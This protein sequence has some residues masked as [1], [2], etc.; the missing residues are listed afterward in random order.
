MELC[1]QGLN[2][3]C[4]SPA[5]PC[6]APLL[7]RWLRDVPAALR[8]SAHEESVMEWLS[9]TPGSIPHHTTTT[10]L[11]L[12]LQAECPNQGSA[13]CASSFANLPMGGSTDGGIHSVGQHTGWPMGSPGVHLPCLA[14]DSSDIPL[15]EA[16]SGPQ[17]MTGGRLA[18][19]IQLRDNM[20]K[21]FLFPHACF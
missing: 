12:Q 9:E 21:C 3:S 4:K 7:P 20:P 10:L 16:L 18:N 11:L 14:R 2:S 13:A 15:G 6:H 5:A 8:R 19:S 1:C 17:Q